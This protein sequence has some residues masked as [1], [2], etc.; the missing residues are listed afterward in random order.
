M[1]KKNASPYRL[2]YKK[3]ISKQAM[4][5]RSDYEQMLRDRLRPFNFREITMSNDVSISSID[6]D[7][8]RD[9]AKGLHRMAEILGIN[10]E[11]IGLGGNV[12]L[13]FSSQIEYEKY[14]RLNGAFDKDF[15]ISIDPLWTSFAHEWGH[16]LDAYVYNIRNGLQPNVIN[17]EQCGIF[18]RYERNGFES[19][20]MNFPSD[21]KK[22]SAEADREYFHSIT[23]RYLQLNSEM[24]ARGFET[25]IAKEF[26]RQGFRECGIVS[27]FDTYNKKQFPHGNEV[28]VF[29]DKVKQMVGMLSNK[30]IIC[31]E[32]KSSLRGE[33]ESDAVLDEAVS[34]S[35]IVA[36]T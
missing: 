2:I 13:V 32:Q 31:K 14:G 4:T 5:A 29:S 30:G 1:N 35:D 17:K 27:P 36:S 18:L 11:D 26:Q 19:N 21:Y 10:Y 6:T 34:L 8:I 25:Y 22:R 15:N 3:V 28:D 7:V 24:F 20:S 23:K 16:A 9:Y 33:K 12:A